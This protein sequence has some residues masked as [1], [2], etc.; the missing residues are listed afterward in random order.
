MANTQDQHR[1][2]TK[3]EEVVGLKFTNVRG[4]Y[5]I[6]LVPVAVS[7]FLTLSV[8]AMTPILKTVGW[9]LLLGSIISYTAWFL[10]SSTTLT[11]RKVF[12]LLGRAVFILWF[13]GLLGLT[14]YVA[15]TGSMVVGEETLRV[16][17]IIF[18]FF[19][20]ISAA[21]IR[22]QEAGLALFLGIISLLMVIWIALR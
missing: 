6:L 11:Q 4:L 15:I 8:G 21:L 2:L 3:L 22:K 10:A 1:E 13:L 18:F 5:L 17:S 14:L 20:T 19:A 16:M 12:H 9:G 7:S